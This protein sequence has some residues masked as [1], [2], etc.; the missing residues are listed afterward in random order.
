MRVLFVGLGSIGTRHLKNLSAVAAQR[1]M[2]LE[3]CALRHGSGALAPDVEA[4]VARQYSDVQQCDGV[5]DAA[6]ITNPTNK[7][8]EMIKALE[9]KAKAFFIEKPI[10]ENANYTPE[11]ACLDGVPAYVACPMRHC[12]TYIELKK[13]LAGQKVFSVR[14]ICSSYLPD[15]RKGVDYREIYSAKKQL[16]GGVTIDLI[17]EWD[18]LADLLG[19]PL[20]IQGFC[21]HYSNLEIDSE[22]LSVYIAQYEDKL[23]ELHLD[24]FGRSY[25]RTAEFFIEQGTVIADFGA[26]TVTLASGEVVDCA[27]PVN[28]RYVREIEYFLQFIAGKVPCINTPQRALQTLKI[29]LACE[30]K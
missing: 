14:A 24:Y 5:F 12:A 1:G 27:E 20:R 2:A 19:A 16:G 9:G 30:G 23:V 6:F 11:Q 18:Y 15:W 26:N 22:D 4:L 29:A 7:H 17:H 8:F 3:V 10:F 28:E 13:Q 25:R 21:G